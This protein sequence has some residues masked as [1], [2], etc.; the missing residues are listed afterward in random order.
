MAATKLQ[1]N[2]T[3]VSFNAT[4]ITRV[5]SV[6][7]DQGGGVNY[8]SGDDNVYDII[9][10]Q[11]S[12]KPKATITCEDPAVLMGFS[13]GASGTFTA[14]HKDAK[15]AAGGAIV[16][17]LA[18]AVVENVSTSGAHQQFGSGSMTLGSFSSDG[19]TNPLSFT[20]S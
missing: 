3:A 10:V 12:G 2:W 7:F 17:L 13:I 16:Y 1:A 4:N 14:T 19:T 15:A 18:N 6:G 20:R 11:L 8:Y 5:S 9:A